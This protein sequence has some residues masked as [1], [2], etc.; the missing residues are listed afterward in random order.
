MELKLAGFSSLTP[1]DLNILIINHGYK[2][3]SDF[4]PSCPFNIYIGNPIFNILEFPF[5]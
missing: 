5:F 2:G 3:G 4:Q 1:R